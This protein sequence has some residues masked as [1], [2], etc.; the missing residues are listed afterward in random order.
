MVFIEEIAIVSVNK[1]FLTRTPVTKS[2]S[3]Y[4]FCNKWLNAETAA[5]YKAFRKDDK[6]SVAALWR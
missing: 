2:K 5:L 3:I 4:K 1:R 6:D